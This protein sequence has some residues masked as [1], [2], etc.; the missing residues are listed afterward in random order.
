MARPRHKG[1]GENAVKIVTTEFIGSERFLGCSSLKELNQRLREVINDLND[2]P[3]PTYNGRSRREIY[4][5]D[6][7]PHMLPV[8]VPAYEFGEWSEEVTV[9]LHYYVRSNGTEYSVPYRY[10]GQKVCLKTTGTMVE[11]YAS[12]DLIAAHAVATEGQRR[13]TNPEHLPSN[14]L[15]MHDEDH[16]CIIERAKRMDEVVKDFVSMHIEKHRNTKASSEMCRQFERKIRLHGK[17]EFVA[18]VS[19]A[20]DRNQIVAAAVYT[21]LKRTPKQG[22]DD[23]LISSPRPTGNIRGADYYNNQGD[24]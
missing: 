4:E 19:E 14:H 17:A 18:A 5:S 6:E 2:R 22:Y 8:E 23:E 10:V 20:I 13:V 15:V 1:A 24:T 3:M 11:V 12:G 7:K 9:P 16:G 21:L